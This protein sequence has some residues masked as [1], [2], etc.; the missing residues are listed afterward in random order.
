[1]RILL[2][3]L[4]ILVGLHASCQEVDLMV[5]LSEQ[6]EGYPIKN[7]KIYLVDGID[8]LLR[9]TNHEGIA[10]FSTNDSIDPI[11]INTLYEILTD[12]HI[13]MLKSKNPS[14]ITIDKVNTSVETNTR[15]I[16][17]IKWLTAGCHGPATMPFDVEELFWDRE[18]SNMLNS[19]E[20]LLTLNENLILVIESTIL[21]SKD[22]EYGKMM[23]RNVRDSLINRGIH[24]DRLSLSSICEID[25]MPNAYNRVDFSVESFDYYPCTGLP[26]INFDKETGQLIETRCDS[27]QFMLNQVKSDDAVYAVIGIYSD[28]TDKTALIKARERAELVRSKLIAMGAPANRLTIYTQYYKAP[29]KDE[30]HDWPFYPDHFTY[31]IGVVMNLAP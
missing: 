19:I 13:H 20:E 17:D 28:R 30:P 27:L 11:R 26:V 6:D 23:A 29:L 25:T 8:T 10:Q 3:L 15:I 1:M 4:L 2:T 31:E 5:I 9:Y 14:L 16:R 12:Q 22:C 7:R 24:P 18:N 21:Q